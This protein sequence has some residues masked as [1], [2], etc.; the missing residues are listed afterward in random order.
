MVRVPAFL[1][2]MRVAALSRPHTAREALTRALIV[3][4]VTGAALAPFV[5]TRD[6]DDVLD[7]AGSDFVALLVELDEVGARLDLLEEDPA[8]DPAELQTLRARRAVLEEQT[9]L[10]HIERPGDSGAE[11]SLAPDFRFLDLSGSPVRLSEVNGPAVVNFW[12]S[13]CP[14][15]I[16]EMPDFQRVHERFGDRVTII[17]INRAEPLAIAAEFA[18]STGARYPLVL[19]LDD[20]L[21]RV[22]GV[23]DFMPSTYYIG[24]DGRVAEKVIGFQTLERMLESIGALLGESITVEPGEAETQGFA[25]RATE[26]L[27]SQQANHA[28]VAELFSRFEAE[29]DVITDIGWQRNVVAQARAW[30]VNS[31]EFGALQPPASLRGLAANVGTAFDF[32]LAA[33]DILEAAVSGDPAGGGSPDPERIGGGIALFRD[34]LP[35]FESA[36]AAFQ[37]GLSV[38]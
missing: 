37:E 10:G 25:D 27:E 19:D 8:A 16:E 11:G 12:A 7:V 2:G 18:E 38:R 36:A 3:A 5:I 4:A 20:D 30:R 14:F 33:A 9:L 15:C 24:A 28:I 22:Y 6:A 34:A 35:G 26:I 17:G 1:R 29:S 32:L 21:E 23:G 31:S 13:W